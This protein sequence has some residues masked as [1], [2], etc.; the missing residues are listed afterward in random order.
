MITINKRE[1]EWYENMTIESLLQDKK[2]TFPRIVV[3]VNG[4][5]IKKS[6]YSVCP[7]NDGDIIDAIHMI[8]GG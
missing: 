1:H 5:V 2:Y 7:I 3:K 8:G 6:E 4:K